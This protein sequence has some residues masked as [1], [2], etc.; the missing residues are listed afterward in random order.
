MKFAGNSFSKQKLIDDENTSFMN[1]NGFHYT[2]DC[3]HRFI[4]FRDQLLKV[5]VGTLG[6]FDGSIIIW[7]TS[8]D[9][10]GT[11]VTDESCHTLYSIHAKI[12]KVFRAAPFVFE[13]SKTLH[14]RPRNSSR[15][16]IEAL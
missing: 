15:N 4:R 6:D 10:I 7:D 12:R 5:P 14:K 1:R 3:S 8:Y 13:H 2:F 16:I 9:R 11:I